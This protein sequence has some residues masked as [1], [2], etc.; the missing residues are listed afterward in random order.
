[1]TGKSKVVNTRSYKYPIRPKVRYN[2]PHVD[3]HLL[4]VDYIS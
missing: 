2:R 1:M 4:Y 3:R